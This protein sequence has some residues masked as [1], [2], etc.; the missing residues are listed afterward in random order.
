M[1]V[2][3]NGNDGDSGSNQSNPPGQDPTPGIVSVASYYDQNT[4]TRDGVVSDYS[5]RGDATRPSTWPDISAPG[6]NIE[7]ACRPWLP[8]CS[9]G[10]A[11][12]NGLGLLDIGTFNTISGTSMAAPHIA[13]II[14]QLFEAKPT[15]TPAEVE[16]ALKSTAYKYTDGAAYTA[17]GPY[18]SSYDKGAGLS[19]S[20]P[21]PGR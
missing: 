9:T 14:A 6:E 8:I 15:A 13:G 2:W 16:N 20:S 11:P 1:T 21:P 5:S 18:T 12:N 19:T 10:L 7:S 4:G 3:A 17:V